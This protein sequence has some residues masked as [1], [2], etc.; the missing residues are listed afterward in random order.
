MKI[1]LIYPYFIDERIH[2]YDVSVVPIGLYYVGAMLKENNYAVDILNWHNVNQ[3]PHVIREVLSRENPDVIGFSILHAN[4]WGGIEIARIAKEINPNVKI[5]FG[6]IGA[7]FL[8]EHLLTHFNDIDFIVLGEGE[9]SF[10]N[11]IHSLEKG[12]HDS[13]RKLKGIAFK[14][15]SKPYKTKPATPIEDLDRLPLPSK[16][17]QYHH[18]TSTRG[19]PGNCTFCGSPMFWGHKVR[20]HSPSYFVDQLEQLK[21]NGIRSFYFSDDTFTLKKKHAIAICRKIIQRKMNITWV[22]ISQVSYI[23]EEV[24]SWMRKAGC[25]QISYG[26]ESGSEKIRD[27]LQKKIKTDQIRNA[28]SLTKKYGILARAYFI[29]GSPGENGDTIR[30]TIQLIHDIK[31]LSVIFYILDIFPGT[32]LYGDFKKK[33]NISDDIWLNQVEDIMYFENDPDLSQE[34]VLAF[35]KEL[36]TDFYE[37]LLEFVDDIE[38]VQ[39]KAFDKRHADFYSRLGMTFSLGDY[40]TINAI[41][42]KTEFAEKLFRK[43][44]S[45]APDQT[46]YQ[47]LGMIFQK[48]KNFKTSIAILSEGLSHFPDNIDMNLCQGINYM[49]IKDFRKA[50]SFFLLFRDAEKTIPYIVHCYRQL[51]DIKNALSFSNKLKR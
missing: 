39:D 43:S 14:H 25:T 34:M 10:L 32:K 18:V 42:E 46:A 21:K 38:L 8:W 12:D 40:S 37:H 31:P 51:G 22:A 6:G 45:F 16:Y 44:I 5:V 24:L 15:D 19:C 47:G 30:E 29:Y 28:F 50:L 27:T 9:Y 1:L 23:D 7:A 35:G 17:F 20:S 49:N 2:E 11:L 4:R 48:Q 36:R 13:I 33:L 26:V 3:T 41:K